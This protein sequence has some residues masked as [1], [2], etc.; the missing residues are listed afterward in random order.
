V[1]EGGGRR[2]AMRLGRYLQAGAGIVGLGLRRR[3]GRHGRNC[4]YVRNLEISGGLPGA[5]ERVNLP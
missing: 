4:A 1:V 3:W 2:N 5:I